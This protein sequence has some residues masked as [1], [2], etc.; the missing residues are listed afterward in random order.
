MK[1]NLISTPP[2]H[3]E[4]LQANSVSY[5]STLIG[6]AHWPSLL[7]T[8]TLSILPIPQLT[9]VIAPTPGG[10]YSLHLST[11]PVNLCKHVSDG[12][13]VSNEEQHRLSRY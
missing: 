2:G 11:L 7:H 3:F 12:F 1:G 6:K 8:G 13:E 10:Y 9:T 5:V 4:W